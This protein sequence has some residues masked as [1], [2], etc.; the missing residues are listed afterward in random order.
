[1]LS[2]N[3]QDEAVTDIVFTVFGGRTGAKFV[4]VGNSITF[5]LELIG[6][7]GDCRIIT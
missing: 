4:V 2:Q 3:S 6:S 7:Y 1:L 5:T